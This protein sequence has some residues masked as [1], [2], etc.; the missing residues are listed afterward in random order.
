MTNRSIR[1]LFIV[2]L[3]I[4]LSAPAFAA[5]TRL[6]KPVFGSGKLVGK[7]GDVQN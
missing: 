7:I 6:E 4:A 5:E 3:M 1:T 2:L